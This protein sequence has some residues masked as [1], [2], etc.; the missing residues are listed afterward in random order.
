M[1]LYIM[2]LLNISS[3]QG[4]LGSYPVNLHIAIPNILSRL[5]FVCF[6]SLTMTV[7]QYSVYLICQG[8]ILTTICNICTYSAFFHSGCF[9]AQ[10]AACKHC[11]TFNLLVCSS[12][13]RMPNTLPY[14][15]Y[16][17]LQFPRNQNINYL[18]KYIACYSRY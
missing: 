4:V 7:I 10:D 5:P 1:M 15:L 8:I 16:W 3:C 6:C 9:F 13:E 18:T 14:V 11:A 12:H 17:F 2:K